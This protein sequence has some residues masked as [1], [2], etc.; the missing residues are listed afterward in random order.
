MTW[1]LAA[2]VC[3]APRTILVSQDLL[4][5]AVVGDTTLAWLDRH[6]DAIL[7]EAERLLITAR[8]IADELSIDR[9]TC[10]E[11]AQQALRLASSGMEDLLI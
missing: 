4:P 5:A 6:R 11:E 10:A 2:D 9:L 3:G 8:S 1:C 7:I